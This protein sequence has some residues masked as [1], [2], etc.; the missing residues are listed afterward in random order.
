MPSPDPRRIPVHVPVA[1]DQ[2]PG[3]VPGH[4]HHRLAAL[5]EHDEPAEHEGGAEQRVEQAGGR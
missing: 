1:L 3:A 5:H 4:T 2:R